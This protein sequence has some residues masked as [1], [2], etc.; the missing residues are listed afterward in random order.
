MKRFS[1]VAWV[2]MLGMVAASPVAAQ[3]ARTAKPFH[4]DDVTRIERVVL[5]VR[6][7]AKP[8]L[9]IVP[10]IGPAASFACDTAHPVGGWTLCTVGVPRGQPVQLSVT[11]QQTGRLPRAAVGP[12]FHGPCTMSSNLTVCTVTPGDAT[13]VTMLN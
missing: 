12:D 2:G 3:T 13:V 11:I 1:V 8:Y 6:Y 4:R 9:S 10:S 7:H 5:T